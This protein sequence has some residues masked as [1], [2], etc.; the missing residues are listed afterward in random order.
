MRL[1]K[2]IRFIDRRD[3]QSRVFLNLEC[4]HNLVIKML[5]GGELPANWTAGGD[6]MCPHCPEPSPVEVK[7]AKTAQQ[8]YKE[9][10]EP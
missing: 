4:R 8:L 7:Q 2:C 5:D 6:V 3:S 10:G 9:A 1:R